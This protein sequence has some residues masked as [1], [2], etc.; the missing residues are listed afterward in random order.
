MDEL[1]VVTVE[2]REGALYVFPDVPRS[3]MTTAVERIDWARL[4]V[5]V[6]VNVSGAVL[7]LPSRIVNTIS[8]DGISHHGPALPEL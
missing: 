3:T 2:T 4:E 1:I 8:Y 6:L 7:S 5:F